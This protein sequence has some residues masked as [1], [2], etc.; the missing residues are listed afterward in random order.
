MVMPFPMIAFRLGRFKLLN[1]KGFALPNS[2]LAV[3]WLE[4]NPTKNWAH[5]VVADQLPINT[6]A[7][8]RSAVY[9]AASDESD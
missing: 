3:Y 4:R 1:A 5:L 8:H 7:G 2:A 9:R 6:P